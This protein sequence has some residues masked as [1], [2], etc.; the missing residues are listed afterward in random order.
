MT[1]PTVRASGTFDIGGDLTV[2]RLGFGAMRIT[3]PASG[4]PRPTPTRRVACWRACPSSASTSID[5]AD[6]YG[7]FVSED[8]IRE[9]LHPYRGML[10][11]TKGGLTATARMSGSPSAARSTCASACS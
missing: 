11:A 9:V 7:P 5:T 8:L 10:V 1:D 2:H 3:G 4:A 6:S